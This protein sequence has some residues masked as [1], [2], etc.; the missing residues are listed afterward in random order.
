M[1]IAEKIAVAVVSDGKDDCWFCSEKPKETAK[2]DLNEDPSSIG[3]P[4]ND[5]RNNS[6]ALG[7]A[8]GSRPS[9]VI[10]IPGVGEA[11]EVVPGA[12]HLI[13]GNASL[14]R[15]GELIDF[16]KAGKKIRADVGYDVNSR[17][18]GIWL[19]GSYGVNA[20]SVVG[21]KWSQFSYQDEYAKAAMTR[22]GAQFHDSHPTYSDRLKTTLRTIANRIVVKYPE[23]CPGCDKQISDKARPP[24]GIVGRLNA[25]S[26][27]H[28]T[29]LAGPPRKWPVR[30]GYFTSRRSV[31]MTLEP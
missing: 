6:S 25:V 31:L 13:P 28:R 29:F 12:H 23:K 20:Q 9:W 16:L 14:A 2:T 21:K 17:E 10:T 7:S 30:S 27:R 3:L 8:L 1:E 18:N 15:V 19:P 24:Y 26:R 5:L 11:A 22:A 4:E